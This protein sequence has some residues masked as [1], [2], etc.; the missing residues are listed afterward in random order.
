GAAGVNAC[1]KFGF[2]ISMSAFNYSQAE[3]ASTTGGGATELPR[4]VEPAR[5]SAPDMPSPFG[6][7][8]A[9]PTLW[10]LVEQFVG[11]FWPD[12][13][14]QQ[15]RAAASAWRTF[16]T[17]LGSSAGEVHAAG[18]AVGAHDIPEGT[19][20]TAAIGQASKG[21]NALAA[22]CRATAGQLDSFAGQV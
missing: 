8:I 9:A 10:F 18:P 11:D 7:G 13:K 21:L 19:R 6:S 12:G 1:R 2:G 5:F 16:G 17:A 15:C 20:I 22:Q 4:P 3:A 14:P